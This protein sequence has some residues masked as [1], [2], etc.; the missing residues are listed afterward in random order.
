MAQAAMRYEAAASTAPVDETLPDMRFRA[1]LGAEAWA[2]LPAAVRARFAK[3]LL[4]GRS[5]TYAGQVETCRMHVAG[6]ALAQ[7]CRLIGAPLP[8]GRDAGVAAVVTVTEDGAAGG[9]VWTRMYARPSGFPQVI[10]SAKRFAGPTGLEEYL[11]MGFGIALRVEASAYGI[12]FVSDH[13]FLRLGIWRLRLPPWLAPG[14]LTIDHEDLG[15]GSF[16]FTL[17]L[18]HRLLGELVRQVGHFRD[19]PEVPARLGPE[20]IREL[21]P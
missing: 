16:A 2:G 18:R 12:R 3:R 15:G 13:Y 4:P 14:A 8:L 5:V 21:L 7:A 6:W 20:A 19:Q 17:A 11:G 9:Q 1:L 10:H